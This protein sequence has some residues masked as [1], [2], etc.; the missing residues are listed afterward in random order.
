MRSL[1][2][3]KQHL[4]TVSIKP[5]THPARPSLLSP[6]SSAPGMIY[7]NKQDMIATICYIV[8]ILAFQ[9]PSSSAVIEEGDGFAH[10]FSRVTRAVVVKALAKLGA[11]FDVMVTRHEGEHKLLGSY[12]PEIMESGA[13]NRSPWDGLRLQSGD[14]GF[15]DWNTAVQDFRGAV[16]RALEDAHMTQE[17][18]DLVVSNLPI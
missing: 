3:R 18:I 14:V 7:G 5:L 1:L 17:A 6:S 2:R 9:N 11:A 16:T 13:L 4:F 8:D 15:L 10:L 12:R